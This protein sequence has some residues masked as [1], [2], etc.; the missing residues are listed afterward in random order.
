[1]EN[2][3]LTSELKGNRTLAT[4]LFTDCVG[5]SA[6]M[7]VNEE[8]TLD[9]IRRDLR[10][11]RRI[12]EGFEGRVLKS[13]G[14]G[15][16]MCFSSAVKAVECAIAIQQAIAEAVH[17]LPPSDALM[18]R[19]G[20][21]LA[22]MYI[23]ATDVM[24][25]GVN[26]AARLQTEAEPGG[27]CIS[28][29][30]YDV[31][32]TALSLVAEYLGPRELKN[33]REIVPAYKI[34]LDSANLTSDRYAETVHFFEQSSNISRIR[35]LI[36]YVCKNR[37]ENNENKLTNMSL[38]GIIHEFLAL[39]SNY[40]QLKNLL[41]AAVGTL[42]KQSEYAVVADEILQGV[43]RFYSAENAN[44]IRE[45][46]AAG[47]P[48][49]LATGSNQAPVLNLPMYQQL[50]QKLDHHPD[51]VRLKKLLYY[52]CR[53]RWE[54]DQA[55]LEATSTVQLLK[56]I[57]R[58]VPDLESLKRLV[59]KYVQTLNKRVE[60]SLVAVTLVGH[61]GTLFGETLAE[62][63][64][65]T[66]GS[67]DLATKLNQSDTPAANVIPLP[68]SSDRQQ[69]Y[70]AIATRLDQDPNAL[71]FKKLIFYVCKAQWVKDGS[72]L[73][74]IDTVA[75]LQEL[76][77]LNPSAEKLVE[78]LHTVV[79][80]LSK[81]A[82]Y[83]AIVQVLM[84]KLSPLYQDFASVAIAQPHSRL[85]VASSSNSIVQDRSVETSNT[86]RDVVSNSTPVS[87]V[88]S[89]TISLFDV[90]LGILKYTNPLR[91][92]IL[93]F[94]AL[95]SDFS[96]NEQDWF[97]LKMYELDGL[98]R[99]LV[100]SCQN[101]TDL[102]YLLYSTA[103]RLKQPEELVATAETVS[104]YLRTFYI[105][106]NPSLLNGSSTDETKIS[107]DDYEA[108]TQGMTSLESYEQT[109]GLALAPPSLEPLGKPS[110]NSSPGSRQLSSLEQ[111]SVSG[112]IG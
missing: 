104:K 72:Q 6:R 37:W 13:T 69:Q 97:N 61:L 63:S 62:V 109:R 80:R 64:T 74:T 12:C 78:V 76:H 107:L 17:S 42:T 2:E 68:L 108:A 65:G 60:Y 75:L 1:M 58:L 11:M 59:D 84:Q 36:F 102:E 105:H 99:G 87:P 15:L 111:D 51:T 83:T 66:P 38:K 94:S 3:M 91:A 67:L 110:N 54:S 43:A 33:I 8:H 14:D 22:D 28:Q 50:S 27:I 49:P 30:V 5:F 73:A 46:T 34:L 39:A 29:T 88:Q 24:G 79:Q 23:T 100:K 112:G 47:A 96:F 56:E 7:S 18:H 106:G 90:R 45:G 16:L 26:I 86:G 89:S 55:R 25:N 20:I 71:R 21:H 82:E 70:V 44:W 48:L 81:R 31:A 9:L 19:I 41:H 53:R 52:I 40:D 35:K 98:L 85:N 103:R 77:R 101:Y 95:H 32:K 4:V 10:L 57:H 93:A 92:K